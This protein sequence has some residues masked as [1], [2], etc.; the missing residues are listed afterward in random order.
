M[1]KTK[2]KKFKL[3]N[4]AIIFIIAIFFIIDRYLKK[5]AISF[6]EKELILIKNLFSFQFTPNRNIAFS[7][8]LPINITLPLT[9]IIITGLIAFLIFLI[10]KEKLNNLYLFSLLLIIFGAISNLIDRLEFKYI[11]DYLYIKNFSV[12]NLADLMISLG[13]LLYLV[14]LYKNNS[15]S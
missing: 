3:N 9:I 1:N 6:Q 11:I 8:P 12:L 5:V 15:P 13:A 14:K 10:K 7:L 4:I 2:K